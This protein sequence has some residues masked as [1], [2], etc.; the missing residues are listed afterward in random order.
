MIKKDILE[1]YNIKPTSFKKINNIIVA[2][3]NNKQVVFKKV[4]EKKNALFDYLKSRSFN[5]MPEYIYDS[6]YE[7]SPYIKSY[8]VDDATKAED[9]IN[10]V[11]LLHLK[12]TSY[13]KTNLDD[14]KK[15]YEDLKEQIYYLKNY[16]EDM[17]EI[18]ENDVYMSPSS[19]LLVRNIT[20]VYNALSYCENELDSFYEE[21][22]SLDKI[23][24]VTLHNNLDLSHILVGE[25]KYLI[26]WDKSKTDMPLYDIY[27]FYQ[28]YYQTLDFDILISQYEERYPLLSYERKLLF[29]MI[30]LPK[31]IEFTHDEY[32][33]TTNVNDL[34]YYLFKGDSIISP[35]YSKNE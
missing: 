17:N 30:S 4:K 26:S 23:R 13:K 21:V 22:K 9:L 27:N 10:I 15:I 5:Y 34:F 32:V 24:V 2:G 18:I 12:T 11:S 28:K 19:Y 1:R 29:I 8:N 25:G 16:Y 7:I 20:K 6:N 3:E 33:N 31:K 14:M 35:Y